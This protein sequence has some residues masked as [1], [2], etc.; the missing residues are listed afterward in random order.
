MGP[1]AVGGTIGFHR[2]PID[3][4]VYALRELVLDALRTKGGVETAADGGNVR[5]VQ[6]DGRQIRVETLA[7]E[8]RTWLDPAVTTAPR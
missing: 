8:G 1:H 7:R 3:V 6:L 5:S 2:G 4:L